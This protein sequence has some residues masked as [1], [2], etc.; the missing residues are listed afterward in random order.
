VSF[1]V[2]YGVVLHH[3]VSSKGLEVDKA[4]V[5]I[6]QSL[7]YPQCVKEVRSFLSYTGCYRRFIK[8]FTKIVCPLCALLIKDASFDFNEDCRRAFDQL[9]L[10]LTTTPIVQPPNWVIPFE[11]MCDARNK[12]VGVVLGQRVGKVP[13]VI[14]MLPELLP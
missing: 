1:Q 9:K 13:Y 3:I 2:E 5:V 7:P 10:K 12:A 11:L 14:I 6:I 4:K 8:D